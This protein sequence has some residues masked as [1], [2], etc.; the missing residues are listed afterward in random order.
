MVIENILLHYKTPSQYIYWGENGMDVYH[1]PVTGKTFKK[2]KNY[3]VPGIVDIT[4]TQFQEISRELLSLDTG[5]MLNSSQFVF[6][7][8]E[9]EKIPFQEKMRRDVIEWRLKKI[10]PEN[11]DD[12]EHKYFKLSKKRVLSVLFKKVYKEKIESLFAETNIPVI[13]IGNST[14]E[15]LNRARSMRRTFPDFFIEID[16]ALSIII[17]MNKGVPFYIRKFRSNQASGV[18]SEVNKTVNFIKNSNALDPRNYFLVGESLEVD[19]PFIREE[20]GKA[21]FQSLDLKPTNQLFFAR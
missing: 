8:I 3:P 2:T 12:Y 20:L 4:P 1:I 6:N 14:I 10:F 9:F 5:I 18:V 21:G 7:V 15:V 13:F 17:F 19:I 11:I 16:K